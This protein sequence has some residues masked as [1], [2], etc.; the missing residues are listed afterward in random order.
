MT[1]GRD[2]TGT[3]YSEKYAVVFDTNSY[4]NLIR[5]T[6][7]EVIETTI[8]QIKEKEARKNIM[9]KAVTLNRLKVTQQILTTT[10]W[11]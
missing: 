3:R 10:L 11:R 2:D 7:I 1:T 8:A 6:A 5:E 4:R 9:A